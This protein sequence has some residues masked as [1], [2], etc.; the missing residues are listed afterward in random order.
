MTGWLKSIFYKSTY[1]P[2]RELVLLLCLDVTACFWVFEI[3]PPLPLYCQQLSYHTE[4]RTPLSQQWPEK[5]RY[6]TLQHGL[7]I[8][9]NLTLF[10]LDTS[11]Q[12]LWQRVKTKMKYHVRRNF[13]WV[14]TVSQDKN[15]LRCGPRARHIYPSSVLV[16]DPSLFNWKIVD[17][18]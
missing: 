17:G 4:H 1:L 9:L 5:G 3:T 6:D 2:P 10:I 7:Y 12:V 16:Q 13:I 8:P 15:N 11:K 14:C 18:T